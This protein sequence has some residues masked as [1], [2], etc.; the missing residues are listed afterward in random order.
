MLAAAAAVGRRA[1]GAA[2]TG[3]ATPSFVVADGLFA[4][5]RHRCLDDWHRYVGHDFVRGIGDG[6]LPEAAFRHYLAQDYLFLVHF[7]RAWALA[8]Y[9][10]ESLA[11]MRHA[12]RMLAAILDVEMGLHVK[13]CAEWG[14]SEAEMRSAPEATATMAYTRYVLE[15]GLAGDLLDL[16][17]ALAPCVMGY[18]EI[19]MELRADPKAQRDGNPYRDWIAMYAGDEYQALALEAVAELDRLWRERAGGGRIDSLARTF[20]EATRLEIAFWQMGLDRST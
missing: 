13:Y 6:T 12:G 8:V 20:R 10:S 7:A 19:G 5:L 1:G 16:Q 3:R 18:A 15:R 2:V 9:K 14:I 17:V 11:E 4:R